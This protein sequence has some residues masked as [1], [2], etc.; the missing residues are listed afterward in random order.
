MASLSSRLRWLRISPGRLVGVLLAVEGLL[1]LSNWLDWPHWHK[2]YAV[3]I[4]VATVGL[5]LVAMLLWFLIAFLFRQL[6]FQ[7]SIRSLLVLTVAVAIVCSWMTVEMRR[8]RERRDLVDEIQKAGG[9]VLYDYVDNGS[10]KLILKRSG[11]AWLRSLLGDDFFSHVTVMVFDNTPITNAEMEH[12]R[13]FTRLESLSLNVTRV[14][15]AGLEHIAG[16]THIQFLQLGSTN[17]TDAGLQHLQALG[18]LC[19]LNLG[20]TH[21]TDTGLWQLQGLGNLRL[22]S[23]KHTQVTNEG[24]KHL[25][26][27][28]RLSFLDLT[29]T[30]VTDGGLADL[31]KLTQLQELRLRGTDVTDAGIRRLQRALPNRR[32]S[33]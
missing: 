18:K 15:D 4:A 22:L 33:N 32:I 24:L 8:A 19:V 10:G 2:G 12:I 1:W 29:E 3:L 20:N 7:F 5:V 30:K 6:R 26:T 28:P 11:P 9:H 27:L 23:L 16:L 21:I 14:T 31:E 25:C 13:G 17:V